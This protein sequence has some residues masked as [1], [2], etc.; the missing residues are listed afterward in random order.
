MPPTDQSEI[1]RGI[2]SSD[3]CTTGSDFES[4]NFNDQMAARIVELEEILKQLT[5][6]AE[7]FIILVRFLLIVCFFHVPLTKHICSVISAKIS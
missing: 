4:N 6:K 5:V 1:P 7:Y 2:Q 3:N